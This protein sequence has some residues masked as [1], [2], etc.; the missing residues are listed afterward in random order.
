MNV[1]EACAILEIPTGSSLEDVNKAFRLKAAKYH[2]DVNKEP[3][4]E[5]TFK[6][7]NEANQLL[8]KHGTY[9]ASAPPIYNYRDEFVEELQRQ[10]RDVFSS[11]SGG[12]TRAG[13]R[14]SI[15]AEPIIV[16]LEIPF[17]MSVTG[18]IKDVTYERI[19]KCQSCNSVQCQKCNGVGRRK[20]GGQDKELPCT[21]CKG[22]GK[23]LT[24]CE[25]CKGTRTTK[26]ID[27][28]KVTIPP[29]VVSGS[30]FNLCRI[31]KE[32][33]KEPSDKE[34]LDNV[35]VVINVLSDPDMYLQGTDV[36]SITELSLLE[37]LKGTK[38][39]L[40]TV[41]GEKTLVFKPKTRHGDTVRVSGF[42][43][44]PNGAHIFVVSVNYPEDVSGLISVLEPEVSGQEG[45]T[46]GL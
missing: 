38:K 20:Y 10:M 13:F 12:W 41:N 18:G 27:T 24:S 32:D 1:Q 25:V 17:E 14:V 42:G 28:K 3:N 15:R 30:R 34:A 19:V 23:L 29:G 21:T 39:K 36:I 8:V 7:I 33:F 4:A 31:I 40:R 9:V 6:K 46:S 35:I 11:P 5:A 2:P 16:S 44:P 22:S 26:V 43:V 45:D 37:A